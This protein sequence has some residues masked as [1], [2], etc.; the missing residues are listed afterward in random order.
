VSQSR[1]RSARPVAT[2][3]VCYRTSQQIRR[4]ADKLLPTALRDTDGLEDERR[5]IVSVF[6]GPPPEVKSPA[7]VAA[8]AAAVRETVEAWL[9]DGIAPC[10]IGLFVRTPQLVARARAAIAGLAGVAEMTTAPMG[11]AEGLEFRAVVVMAC[12]E[13]ITAA[14]RAR[15]RCGRR[16]GTRR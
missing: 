14:R 8:E 2:L 9:R 13:G 16:G 11:L 10:E 7:T 6:D 15:R 3:K 12:D 1:R 5:G 4:P